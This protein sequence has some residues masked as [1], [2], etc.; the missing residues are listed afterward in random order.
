VDRFRI[1]RGLPPKPLK[2]DDCPKCVIE[3]DFVAIIVPSHKATKETADI[4]YS[5]VP[6][7]YAVFV[8]DALEPLELIHLAE[9]T[10][11]IGT[12]QMARQ[13]LRI[14]DDHRWSSIDMERLQALNFNFLKNFVGSGFQIWADNVIGSFWGNPGN[15]IRVHKLSAHRIL[16][17][18]DKG[19]SLYEKHHRAVHCLNNRLIPELIGDPLM[20]F[21]IRIPNTLVSLTFENDD[22]LFIG[23]VRE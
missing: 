6:K 1:L 10:M 5:Q 16:R 18:I 20:G 23:N 19:S 13:T 2:W 7:P 8:S 9:K 14:P 22:S 11:V 21:S 4:L 17:F 12:Y 15:P 3:D